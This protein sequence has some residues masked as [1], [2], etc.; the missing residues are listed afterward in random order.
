MDILYSSLL[1]KSMIQYE[2]QDFITAKYMKVLQL[3]TIC[4]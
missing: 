4:R 2:D 1:E 3:R